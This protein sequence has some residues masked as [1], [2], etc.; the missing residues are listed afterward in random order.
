VERD[1]FSA[2]PVVAM[3]A[4]THGVAVAGLVLSADGVPE[5]GAAGGPTAG[6]GA[7]R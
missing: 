6:F 3:G 1:P 4:T 7:G 5:A 2:Q